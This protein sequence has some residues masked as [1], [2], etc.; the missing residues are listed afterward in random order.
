[1][2]NFSLTEKESKLAQ[3]GDIQWKYF[4]EEI[5]YQNVGGDPAA[6]CFN[7]KDG[8]D[9]GF[10]KHE[11]AG[12]IGSLEKKNIIDIEDRTEQFGGPLYWL[13]E[14]FINFIAHNN[15]KNK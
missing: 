6:F 15:K 11:L 3:C 7:L 14:S 4:T 10:K 12:V 1:M 13:T 8:I 2:S 5:G 9:A